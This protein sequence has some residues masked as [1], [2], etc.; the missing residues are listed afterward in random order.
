MID[1]E[2]HR[3]H[4]EGL[5]ADLEGGKWVLWIV[6]SVED[7]AA[8]INHPQRRILIPAMAVRAS[9]GRQIVVVRRL[10]SDNIQKDV[11]DGF[12]ARGQGDKPELKDPRRFL[13]HLV[14]HEVA[15][16]VLD[17]KDE[18]PCDAWAFSRMPG[19]VP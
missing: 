16:H 18:E 14:L 1:V 9:D 10:L 15:H 3:D 6:D 2:Q 11:L 12:L 13:E 17:T 19:R 4:L 8:S 7:W 5:L